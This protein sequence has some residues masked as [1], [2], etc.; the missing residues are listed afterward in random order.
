MG[1]QHDK[2]QTPAERAHWEQAEQRERNLWR[3]SFI[4]IALLSIGLGL[5][6]IHI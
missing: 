1:E 2:P 6:L 4:I 3:S 5:S